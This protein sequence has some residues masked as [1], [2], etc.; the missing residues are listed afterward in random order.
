[1]NSPQTHPN[2]PLDAGVAS[3][4]LPGLVAFFEGLKPS[5]LARLDQVYAEHCRFKDPFNEV[6]GLIPIR[7]IFAHMFTALEE[8]HFVVLDRIA[9]GDQAFLSWDFRFRFKGQVKGQTKSDTAWPCIKGATH[10]RLNAQGLVTE[11][12]DYWD[13]AEELYEKLPVLGPLMRWLKRRVMAN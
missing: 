7:A 5:D 10:V 13:A 11:H 12:R 4:A 8:P 6:V 1:M 9:Q 3:Q 2:D